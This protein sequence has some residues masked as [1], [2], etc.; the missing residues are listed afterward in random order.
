M[1]LWRVNEGEGLA[2]V[3]HTVLWVLSAVGAIS[4]ALGQAGGDLPS[5]PAAVARKPGRAEVRSLGGLLKDAAPTP[6]PEAP[7]SGGLE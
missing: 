2:G 1:S 7:D 6:H 5:L 4:F 3:R